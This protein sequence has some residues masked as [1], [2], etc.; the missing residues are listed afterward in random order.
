MSLTGRFWFRKTW[1]G[2]VI[3]LVEEAKPKW[4]AKRG[5]VKLRWRDA[6]LLDFAEF[7]MRPLM[8]LQKSQQRPQTLPLGSATTPRPLSTVKSE[9]MVSMRTTAA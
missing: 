3:L 4:F 5:T 1:R 2:K 7:A 6:K 9:G 8:D